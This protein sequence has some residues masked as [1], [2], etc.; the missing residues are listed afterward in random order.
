M[1]SVL[2]F[3]GIEN[4]EAVFLDYDYNEHYFGVETIRGEGD[5]DGTYTTKYL[6]NNGKSLLTL[7]QI[8]QWENTS[9]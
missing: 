6:G 5:N 8:K 9:I 2:L 4:G 3:E 7:E 1:K